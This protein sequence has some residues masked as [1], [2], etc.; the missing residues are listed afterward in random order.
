MNAELRRNF[1][2][3]ISSHRLIAFPV[4]ILLISWLT[5]MTS[6]PNDMIMINAWILGF[7][8]VL[9]GS[10]LTANSLTEEV[11]NRTWE[12]QRMLPMYPWTMTWGKILGS[13]L[14]VW[15]GSAIC[16]GL[17]LITASTKQI[18][19]N[20]YSLANLLCF[21]LFSQVFAFYLSVLLH[22]LHSIEGRFRVFSIQALSVITGLSIFSLGADSI[23][24]SQQ[25]QVLVS[26]Y[27]F[28]IP[29][30]SFILLSW[31]AFLSFAFAGSYRL[32][33]LELQCQNLPWFWLLFLGFVVGYILGLVPSAEPVKRYPMLLAFQEVFLHPTLAYIIIISFIFLGAYCEP[34]HVIPIRKWMS[35]LEQ[36]L[37]FQAIKLTPT[38]IVALCLAL[39]VWLY[40]LFCTLSYEIPVH[41]GVTKTKMIFWY[42]S[43][44]LFLL[45]D[46]GLLYYFTIDPRSKRGHIASIIYIILLYSLVP[47]LLT[48][49]ADRISHLLTPAFLPFHVSFIKAEIPELSTSML[50]LLA[51]V[52]LAW[53]CVYSRWQLIQ[54]PIAN[55][56]D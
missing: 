6:S 37:W 4:I 29:R 5:W 11:T 42:T 41:E 25:A 33:R 2:L 28:E 24:G 47:G 38:W 34:K 17:I 35:K 12:S 48:L 20:Y 43:L 8:S 14:F 39:P 19:I 26:W 52:G 18:T 46:I 10:R 27:Q 21:G 9:W 56:E 23:I 7:M 15:Y 30:T 1:W 16:L 13:T 54:K 45:R 36:G 50:I 32:L 55:E 49:T 3:E 22:R 53:G 40:L 31:L 44:L 51:Q